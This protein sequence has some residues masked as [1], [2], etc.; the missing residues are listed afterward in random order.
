MNAKPRLTIERASGSH[1]DQIVL[2][3]ESYAL[4]NLAAA[5]REK[6]GFLV[7]GF[8][9]DTYFGWLDDA[10]HFYV[11]RD[12][13]EVSGFILACSSDLIREDEWLKNL[14]RGRHPGKFILLKQICVDKDAIGRGI[15]TALI[16]R[17]R[18]ATPGLVIFGA[19]VMEPRNDRSIRFHERMGF[20]KAFEVT[21]SDGI[22]GGIWMDPRDRG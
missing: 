7:S 9:R 12:E 20:H 3:A 14:I 5:D 11:A 10:D 15:A 17:L 13:H 2:L 8:A 19:I 18:R 22:K 4:A 1:L 21:P 6:Y 16:E